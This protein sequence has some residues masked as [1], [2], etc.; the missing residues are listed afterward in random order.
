MVAALLR[1]RDLGDGMWFDEISTLVRY[2]RPPLNHILTTFDSKNQHLL[3]SLLA[4]ESIGIFGESAWALRLPAAILGVASI[5]ALA[6]FGGLITSRR[7]ALAASALLTFSYHHVWF[8]QNARGY[9]GLLFATLVASALLVKL[10]ARTTWSWRLAIGYAITTALAVYIHI[11]AGLI[12]VGHVIWWGILVLPG[13]NRSWWSS[14]RMPLATFTLTA[15]FSIVL[16]APVLPQIVPT[17]LMPDMGGITNEWKNPVWF[18]AET[19]RSLSQGLPG[20]WLTL[21]VVFFVTILGLASYARQSLAIIWLMLLPVIVTTIAVLASEQNLWPRFFFFA[22]GFGALIV[23]RGLFVAAGLM[24]PARAQTLG[25]VAAAILIVASATT[26]P[27]AWH[28]KQDYLGARAFVDRSRGESDAVVTM[29]MTELPYNTYQQ[30]LWPVVTNTQEL[31]AIESA[32][33]RT[34][35]LVTFPLRLASVKPDLWSYIQRY[36][37]EAATFRGTVAG[38]EILVMTR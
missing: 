12:V 7:E 5:A 9:T 15:L 32:H 29:D 30:L 8:S 20:G 23:I 19:L 14:A 27:R 17:L 31:A 34:W 35:V 2:V 16:Y 36:Y 26:V 37:A 3:Y 21:A 6:W 38:G 10:S 22:A 1:L 11:T 4:H 13:R 18:A 24:W 28:P 33:G 25:M